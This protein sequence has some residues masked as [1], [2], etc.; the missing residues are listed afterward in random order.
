[1]NKS[2]ESFEVWRAVTD[3]FAYCWH[4]RRLMERYGIVPLILGIAVAWTLLHFNVAPDERTVAR[5]SGEILAFLINI[6]PA[7]AWYR[8]VV[9][10]EEAGRRP[11]YTFTRL[12]V[13][14]VLWQILFV[15]PLFL[16]VIIAA[17]PVAA[18][19]AVGKLLWGDAGGYALAAPFA[20]VALAW[21]MYVVTRL[22][23]VIAMAA[24]DTHASFGRA[25]RMSAPI[26]WR[27]TGAVLVL[28]V[29]LVP[30]GLVGIGIEKLFEPHAA[31]PYLGA[32]ID[33]VMG[34]IGLFVLST[35]FGQVYR[36]FAETETAPVDPPAPA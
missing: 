22:S 10:G 8:T 11:I 19:G 31:A 9:Y 2:S 12:E 6:P 15:F 28:I 34:L 13:R 21:V 26:A 17:I 5:F 24:L 16:A 18:A 25:W 36:R 32:A 35:L 29:F 23:L 14:M 4:R 30:I 33:A 27:L 1:V 20:V 7:V 3:A